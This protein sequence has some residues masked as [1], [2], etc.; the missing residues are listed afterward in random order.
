MTAQSMWD[1]AQYEKF[2]HERSLPFFD[3]LAL[4]RRDPEMRVADLGCGTGELTSRLHEGLKARETLAIDSSASMLDKSK[5]FEKNGLHF[6]RMNIE[7]WVPDGEFDLIFS[8]AALHFVS[9]HDELIR[10]FATP[11]RWKSPS[12]RGVAWA[13]NRSR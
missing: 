12:L 10:R 1:P 7:E 13:E 5:P 8:N 9:G 11:G 4:V 2:L 6:E 3:L